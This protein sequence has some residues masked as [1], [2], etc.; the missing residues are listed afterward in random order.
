MV[1]FGQ[2]IR[3]KREKLGLKVKDLAKKVGIHPVYMTQIEK[4]NKLPSPAVYKDIEKV[5]GTELRELY[6]K[7]KYPKLSKQLDSPMS[8]LFM[9]PVDIFGGVFIDYVC[10]S[11]NSNFRK[12]AIELIEEFAPSKS[13]NEHLIGSISSIVKDLRELHYAFQ[14]KYQQNDSKVK[15]LLGIV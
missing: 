10:N 1:K 14:L 3:T 9:N 13:G 8:Q 6:L 15:K 12:I 7:E 11:N 4:H 5:L 2:L